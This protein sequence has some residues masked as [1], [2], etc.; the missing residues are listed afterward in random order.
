MSGIRINSDYRQLE[1]EADRLAKLP[2]VKSEALLNS[3][4]SAGFKATQA[5]VHIDTSSL[6][7]SGKKE[8][9]T[10]GKT[11][12]GVISYGGITTGINNPVDYAIYE[13]RREGTH[14]FFEPL[15]AL[16]ALWVKAILRML[17]K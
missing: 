15:K 10:H 6:K 4:L 9:L 14:D 2:N 7:F 5:A 8:S 12:E 13:K 3:V 1:R 16:D 17:E 11:W